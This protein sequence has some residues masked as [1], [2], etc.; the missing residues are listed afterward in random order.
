MAQALIF[1]ATCFMA[2]V[3]VEVYRPKFCRMGLWF[4]FHGDRVLMF[5]RVRDG[6]KKYVSSN[7]LKVYSTFKELRDERV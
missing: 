3:A 7:S 6:W 2:A 5:W 1:M 4:N